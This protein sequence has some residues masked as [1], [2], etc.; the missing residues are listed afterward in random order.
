MNNLDKY[1]INV[2]ASVTNRDPKEI[3]IFQQAFSEELC[4]FLYIPPELGKKMRFCVIHPT[5]KTVAKFVGK[6][7]IQSAAYDAKGFL[8]QVKMMWVVYTRVY[9]P[10]LSK[11]K[12]ISDN[13]VLLSIGKITGQ[14]R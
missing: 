13:N 4:I 6:D 14:L 2:E 11:D 7:L 1:N 8:N 9:V 3:A 12:P 10:G 5:T